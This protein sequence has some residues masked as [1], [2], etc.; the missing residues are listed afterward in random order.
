MHLTG[1]PAENI[2]HNLIKYFSNGCWNTDTIKFDWFWQRI[3]EAL[4]RN[5]TVI[6][7]SRP[8]YLLEPASNIEPERDYHV[9]D[10]VTL[11]QNGQS[12]RLMRL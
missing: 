4:E 9:L 5:Y 3:V 10:A 6:G 1:I 2:Q 11:Q 12:I 8:N 7:D